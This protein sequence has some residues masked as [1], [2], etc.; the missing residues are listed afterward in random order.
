MITAITR[1][2]PR[3]TPACVV[4]LGQDEE[5]LFRARRQP[6][7]PFDWKMAGRYRLVR[8]YSCSMFELCPV[9]LW[10]LLARPD[11]QKRDESIISDLRTRSFWEFAHLLR[12]PR[13]VLRF[14]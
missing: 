13:L 4:G 7:I 10:E 5:G 12:S 2:I 9:Y 11:V 14:C 3:T 1:A 8:G 6:L